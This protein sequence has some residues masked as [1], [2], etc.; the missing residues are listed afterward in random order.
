[1]WASFEIDR[2]VDVNERAKKHE[3]NGLRFLALF[4]NYTS[5]LCKFGYNI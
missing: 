5:L 4:I 3:Q 1:M 2:A